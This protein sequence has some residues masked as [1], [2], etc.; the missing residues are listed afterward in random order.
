MKAPSARIAEDTC[1]SVMASCDKLLRVSA[2]LETILSLL[3]L[4]EDS[5]GDSL[6]LHCLLTPLKDQLDHAINQIQQAH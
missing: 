5:S 2:G 1:E 4:R 3:E 6:G